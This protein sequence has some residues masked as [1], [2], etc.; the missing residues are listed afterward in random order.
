MS[1]R[2]AKDPTR[3]VMDVRQAAE[4]LGISIDTLYHYA[5]SKFIPAF[6]IGNRWKFRLGKLEEWMDKKAETQA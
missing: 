4:Y 1:T 2:K 3:E 6:R 5:Q